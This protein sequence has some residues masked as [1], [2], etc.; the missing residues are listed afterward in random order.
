MT[1]PGFITTAQA[2]RARAVVEERLIERLKRAVDDYISENDYRPRTPV[3]NYCKLIGLD[4][5]ITPGAGAEFYSADTRTLARNI[6][7][8]SMPSVLR[9][10]FE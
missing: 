6:D 9:R 8:T 7:Q 2:D 10:Y 4:I 5:R 3:A 1:D